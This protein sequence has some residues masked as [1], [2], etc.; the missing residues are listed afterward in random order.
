MRPKIVVRN[1]SRSGEHWTNYAQQ[2]NLAHCH[3]NNPPEQ[4]SVS[5]WTFIPTENRHS[6]ACSKAE[7]LNPRPACAVRHSPPWQTDSRWASQE[8]PRIL[9][10]VKFATARHRSLLRA[11]WT[12]S[13]TPNLGSLT[14]IL[15][16][17]WNLS[18]NL[19]CSLNVR[20]K[21]CTRVKK[22]LA[23][24]P[25]T[26]P[27][28]NEAPNW[29]PRV[30]TVCCLLRAIAHL[31]GRWHVC[32]GWQSKAK[33]GERAAEVPLP[34]QENSASHRLSCDTAFPHRTASRTAVMDTALIVLLSKLQTKLLGRAHLGLLRL[35]LK[36][37]SWVHWSRNS[38]TETR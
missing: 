10:T 6:H 22:A 1:V 13:I 12:Q 16:L 14:S 21:F 34:R 29:G 15:I 4:M 20:C 9:L 23:S 31:V 33:D 3:C 17:S 37:T 2:C 36:Q 32:G 26:C 35:I 7:V 27:A 30:M 19:C 11:S 28:R 38:R 24:R 25:A 5:T 8:T 18:L